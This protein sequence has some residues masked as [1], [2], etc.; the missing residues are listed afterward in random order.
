MGEPWMMPTKDQ[1]QELID[2]TTNI[3]V[4]INKVDGRMFKSK[5]DTSRYILLPPGGLYNPGL[6]TNTPHGYY[7][8]VTS[9]SSSRPY[10]LDF[11]D[12]SNAYA[13]N[14][15]NQSYGF[16]IRPVRQL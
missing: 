1:L 5:S 12:W 9:S 2:N 14:W 11:S 16:S 8:C 3:W 4:T 6:S 13:G 7:W 10:A 15:F